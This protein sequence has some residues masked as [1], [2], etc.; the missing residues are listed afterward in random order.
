[1]QSVH[2]KRLGLQRR[3][4]FSSTVEY[5]KL[6]GNLWET[7]YGTSLNVTKSTT[8]VGSTNLIKFQEKIRFKNDQSRY[9][10]LHNF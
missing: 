8:F 9:F 7:P 6:V 4:D 1:M 2:Y 10:I 3:L 5:T